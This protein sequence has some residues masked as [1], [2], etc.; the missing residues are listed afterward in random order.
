MPTEPSGQEPKTGEPTRRPKAV[1]LLLVG[2]G[3][4]LGLMLVVPENFLFLFEVPLVVVSMSSLAALG[5]L[6]L[7]SVASGRLM[8]KPT[9][10]A[11]VLFVVSTGVLFLLGD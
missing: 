4:Y 3:V 7:I 1:P 10:L 11:G 8:S 2:M 9:A 6:L 5:A